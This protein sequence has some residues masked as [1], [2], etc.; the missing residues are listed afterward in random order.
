MLQCCWGWL[1][2]D[3]LPRPLVAQVANRGVWGSIPTNDMALSGAEPTDIETW[4]GAEP[5]SIEALCGAK[6]TYIE[7]L[8]GAKPTKTFREAKLTG[9]LGI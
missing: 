5:T 9:V 1:Q 3:A 6:H 2:P 8:R 7:A 4:C